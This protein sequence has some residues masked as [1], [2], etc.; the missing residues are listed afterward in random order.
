MRKLYFVN[1]H[2]GDGD[3]LEMHSRVRSPFFIKLEYRHRRHPTW[4]VELSSSTEGDGDH[5][6]LQ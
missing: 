3:G 4:F 2:C 5:Y 6:R 1:L